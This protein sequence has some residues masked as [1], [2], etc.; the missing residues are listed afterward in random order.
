MKR[1]VILC[2][3]SIVS[4]AFAGQS[5]NVALPPNHYEFTHKSTDNHHHQM[6]QEMAQR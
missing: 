4:L 6:T 1:L 2:A 3:L 5:T